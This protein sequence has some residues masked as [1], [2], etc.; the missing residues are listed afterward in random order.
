[1]KLACTGFVSAT[2][3]SVAAANAL[4]LSKLL[5]GGFE[6]D[7]FS[8]PSFV[9][10]RPIVGSKPGFRFVPV[11]NTILNFTRER[12]QRVPLVSVAAG[13]ADTFSYNQLVVRRIAEENRHRNYDLCLWLGDYARGSVAGLPTVSYAQGPPGTDARSVMSRYAEIRNLAG[14]KQALKWRLFA[15]LRLSP[16]GRPPLHHTDRFIIGSRQSANTLAKLYS[17]DPHRISVLPYPIDLDLFKPLSAPSQSG[18]LRVLWLGRIVPRKRLDIFLN[19]ASLAIRYGV[20]LKLTLIGPSGFIPGYE[21]MIRSFPYP[22]R[23]MYHQRIER[24]QVPT[25]LNQQDVLAQPSEEENFGS[26]VAEAQACGL[27]VIVGHTNGNAD[28]LSVRDI[29]LADE[30]PETFAE[31]L[32]EMAQRKV[33][34]QLGEQK[35]SRQAAEQNFHIERVTRALIQI[36]ESVDRKC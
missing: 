25:L 30:R 6:I 26:S 9:D 10:P 27:P 7:F 18:S 12:V 33:A 32:A 21:L 1:M 34:G 28:Y 15:R 5:D 2:A 36:L 29:H 35:V 20:D 13:V 24:I 11:N 31:A 22:D 14:A 8:K 23:L 19:G 3:G 16:L 4:L 17:V